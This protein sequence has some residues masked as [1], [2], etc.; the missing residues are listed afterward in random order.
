MSEMTIALCE[1]TVDQ[2]LQP[3]CGG[4]D[5]AHV[6]ALMDCPES[7]PP[8]VLALDGDLLVLVDG[9]HRL[10]A[11]TRL[12]LQHIPS[13]IVD[14]PVDGDYLRIAFEIN[15]AHGKP[16]SLRDRKSYAQNLLRA[17]SDWSDREIGRRTGLNHETVG[18]MRHGG[19]YGYVAPERKPGEIPEDIGLLDP[20]RFA[21]AT[22]PQKA[23]AG[24][25]QR[26]LQG[27]EDPYPDDDGIPRVEGWHD[28]AT[29][30]EACFVAIGSERAFTL[31]ETLEHHARFLLQIAK[32]RKSL[33]QIA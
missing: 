24:Y 12:G 27:L 15:A 1:I 26:L 25:I 32:E 22:R 3:R 16:L 18:A 23:V 21:K 31:L 29:I 8:I 19:S 9:F 5:E 20:I 13:R 28:S 33:K 11:A 10:E 7:W 14:A 6:L 2:S 30:A 17:H 4:L